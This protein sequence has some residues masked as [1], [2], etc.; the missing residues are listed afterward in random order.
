MPALDERAFNL[1]R[2]LP[3]LGVQGLKIDDRFSFRWLAAEPVGRSREQLVFQMVLSLG[4]KSRCCAI[5]ASVVSPRTTA[6]ATS[7]LNAAECVRRGRLL[8]FAP[9]FT[10]EVLASKNSFHTNR[11]IQISGASSDAMPRAYGTS[12]ET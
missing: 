5:S 10:G 2:Q 1:Q 6:S 12:T 8:I 7:A 3:D 4:C 9:V 11:N